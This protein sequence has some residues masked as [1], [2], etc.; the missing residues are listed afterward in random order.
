MQFILLTHP[1]ERL[2]ATNTGQLVL[3]ALGER[4]QV[5][6]WHRKQPDAALLAA[7]EAARVGL[8]FPTDEPLNMTVDSAGDLQA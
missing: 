2:R 7:I 8:V 1:R 4:A 5:I 3:Q 6:E